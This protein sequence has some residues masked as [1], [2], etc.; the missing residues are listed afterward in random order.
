MALKEEFLKLQKK[1]IRKNTNRKL[2]IFMAITAI[3]YAF[4]FSSNLF[5][6][7]TF[8]GVDPLKIGSSIESE[9]RK[10]TLLSWTYSKKQ[11]KMEIILNLENLSLDQIKKYSWQ[12]T[13]KFGKKKTEVVID[14]DSLIVLNVYGIKKNFTELKLIMGIRR[15]DKNIDTKFSE[16]S[17]YTNSN[18]VSNV[19]YI[20]TKTVAGYKRQ[21]CF[22]VIKGYEK[23]IEKLE[24]RI[25][26]YEEKIDTANEKIKELN[27]DIKYQTVSEKQATLEKIL[28]ITDKKKDYDDSIKE[29]KNKIKETGKKIE[30]K[31]KQLEEKKYE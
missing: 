15:Q 8:T 28:E 16:L 22:S 20:G 19:S 4:F 31:K 23:E 11:E 9:Q 25:N 29:C 7:P 1:K 3:M 2:Y 14:E 30:L 26:T 27:A 17:F 21:A 6:P 18:I 10:L 13:D 24:K 12:V 5:M